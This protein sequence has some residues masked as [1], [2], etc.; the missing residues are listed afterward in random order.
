MRILDRYL[1]RELVVP[2]VLGIAVFTSVL[3]IVRI[4]KLMDLVVN[5][6]VPLAQMAL[7]FSYIVPA[8]L[9]LTVPM[10]LLLAVLVAFGRLSSDSE[11]IALSAAGT[12]FLRLLR[13]VFVFASTVAAATFILSTVAR[14]WGNT[15]LRA[16]LYEIA[17]DRATA[18]IRPKV[19]SDEF[20][21]LVI[22]VDRVETTTDNLQGILIADT[23]DPDMHN[24]I[25]AQRGWLLGSENHRALTLRLE[26]GGI[27]SAGRPG[28]YQATRFTTYDIALNIDNALSQTRNRPKDPAEMTLR[29]LRATIEKKTANGEP[30]LLEHAEV[31]RKF[32]VPFACLVFASLGVPLGIQSNR[33]AHSRGLSVSLILIFSYYL[34]LT[35]GQNLGER[36]EL[37]VWLGVWLPNIVLSVLGAMLLSQRRPDSPGRVE[38]N[39]IFYHLRNAWGRVPCKHR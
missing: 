34:L 27:Y 21:G 7:I 2:F 11:L 5:R 33:S 37:P 25:Y 32:S 38:W 20:T 35:L 39:R 9:E 4:L 14:P 30:T 19:F 12:S 31:Q 24:T 36:G 18:G 1:L 3:L 15:M 10:A 6:G 23:R 22:Y 17:R 16:G 13:P 8:F 28:G 26:N 29:E